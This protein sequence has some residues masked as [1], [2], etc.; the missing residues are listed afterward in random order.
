MFSWRDDFFKAFIPQNT[1]SSTSKNE[2]LSVTENKAISQIK[3]KLSQKC[4][5]VTKLSYL[6]IHFP[7]NRKLQNC[8]R[9]LSRVTFQNIL[10]NFF[11]IYP[12]LKQN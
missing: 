2:F 10:S 5:P 12:Q 6:L 11:L 9:L 3:Q 8:Q 4:I 1:H 7:K